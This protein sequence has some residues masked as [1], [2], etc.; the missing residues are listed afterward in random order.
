MT[1]QRNATIIIKRKK[2][3][4]G[5]HH[6]GAWKVA[7]ADFVT[8]MMAFFLLMWL[9]G[10]T[11]E[12]QRKGIADY[13]NP[14]IPIS[15]VSG[16]GGGSFGGDSVF[17]EE[18]LTQT[19]AGASESYH[20]QSDK[21]QGQTGVDADAAG[22]A[23][24][25]ATEAE[26]EALA[27]ML[28]ARAGESMVSKDLSRHIMTRVTDQGLIVELFDMPDA[29]LFD[30]DSESPTPLLAELVDLVAGVFALAENQV[31]VASHVRAQPV[32]R[33]N[34]AVWDTSSARAHVIR[35]LLQGSPVD[36]K[37]IQRVSGFADRELVVRNPM[38]VRNNRVELILLR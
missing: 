24:D 15:R 21:S 16:G 7:Y 31:A 5:G 2:V 1:A 28:T 9:L 19:G 18:T 35:G 36:E 17:S 33:M 34:S 20:A 10:T 32:V 23:N 4:A 6:G 30:G 11:S 27:D 22:D 25:N 13:F 26:M 38:S 37:R 12:D 3:I 14:T 29:M 8:A